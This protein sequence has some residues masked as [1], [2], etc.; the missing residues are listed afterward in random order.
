M[1]GAFS[2]RGVGMEEGGLAGEM[3]SGG[4]QLPAR[5]QGPGHGVDTPGSCQQTQGNWGHKRI[6]S[7]TTQVPVMQKK[8][9]VWKKE[10]T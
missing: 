9:S 8:S 1:R 10:H 3:R 6:S 2:Q 5:G 7:L 4:Q